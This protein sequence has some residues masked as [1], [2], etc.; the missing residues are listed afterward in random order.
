MLSPDGN[1]LY[2]LDGQFS[3]RTVHRIRLTPRE[4]ME[5]TRIAVP[6]TSRLNSV[7]FYSHAAVGPR[8]VTVEPLGYATNYLRSGFIDRPR[9]R[10]WFCAW[11]A[12]GR[13]VSFNTQ[14]RTV[15]TSLSLP[16]GDDNP[17]CA[18]MDPVAVFGYFGTYASPA[19]IIKIR[20]S[21]TSRTAALTLPAGDINLASAA[22]DPAGDFA[23][24]GDG[25]N[26]GK[27]IKIRLSDFARVGA[28]VLNAGES[29]FSGM[30]ID[31]QGEFLYAAVA[32][33]YL[34]AGVIKVRLSDFTR[35]GVVPLTAQQNGSLLIDPSGT[36]LYAMGSYVVN[37]G[38]PATPAT[39]DRIRLSDFAKTP[40]SLQMQGDEAFPGA[41]AVDP[42]GQ[43][44][45]A[46][47]NAYTPKIIKISI[48]GLAR[49]GAGNLRPTLEAAVY[50][51]LLDSAGEFA[52]LGQSTSPGRIVTFEV[53]PKPL[54]LGLY[55][56][57]GSTAAGL[58][59]QS[60]RLA[61]TQSGQ[62][63]S[64]P[65]GQGTPATLKMQPGTYALAWQL[66][67]DESAPSFAPGAAGE[68]FRLPMAF[69][70]FPALLQTTD[71]STSW[72]STASR[73]SVY[74]DYDL[75]TGVSGWQDYR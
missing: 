19:K 52:Y 54:R 67:A 71:A 62:W 68:G 42:N 1:T 12:P 72:S 17:S 26:P 7:H 49:Q 23:Y 38:D 46:A 45:L 61:L 53:A 31:P 36:Y 10:A 30:A 35:V 20:L 4:R 8:R 39:L 63:L 41:M 44:L 11:M 50:A 43:F 2:T 56:M 58:M 69:G 22:M 16:A 32:T 33:G 40:P 3:E 37:P 24:F 60:P 34:T 57:M 29:F 48:P 70:S 6:N 5:A 74:L 27:I 15:A 75:E 14:A 28:L 25:S 13:I 47:I 73:W 55:K 21:D 66:D 51:I 65:A 9:N 64:V 18:V 59:W